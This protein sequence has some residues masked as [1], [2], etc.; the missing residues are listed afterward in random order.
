MG[1]KKWWPLVSLFVAPLVLTGSAVG[2]S[3][4]QLGGRLEQARETNFFRWFN[5]QENAQQRNGAQTVITFKPGGQKFRHQVTLL[6]TTDPQDHIQVLELVLARAFVDNPRDGIFARDLAKSFLQA[7]VS[8]RS[9]Q[10][11][12]D[13][14]NEIQYPMFHGPPVISRTAPEDIKLPAAPTPCYQVYLNRQTACTLD[15]ANQRLRLE[16]RRVGETPSLIMAVR[17]Q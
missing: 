5:L 10:G 17:P 9:S 11:L 12:R 6:V 13:L 2:A 7:A 3:F 15:L 1:L 4:G 16:N 8:D 14:I